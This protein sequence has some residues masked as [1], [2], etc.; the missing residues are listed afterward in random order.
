MSQEDKKAPSIFWNLW[1][2]MEVSCRSVAGV[3]LEKRAS[4]WRTLDVTYGSLRLYHTGFH[5]KCN[6]KEITKIPHS[7]RVNK[8]N[9]RHYLSFLLEFTILEPIS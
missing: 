9:S 1:G 5:D 6:A 8:D 7:G 4:V 2:Q 3:W